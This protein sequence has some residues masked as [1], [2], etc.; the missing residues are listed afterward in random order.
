M[1]KISYFIIALFA[2]ASCEKGVGTLYQE[3]SDDGKEIHFLQKSVTK[4]FTKGLTEGTILVDIARPGKT[5]TY[6]VWL[7]LI[8]DDKEHFTVPTKVEIK[9][10]EYSTPVEIKVDLASLMVGSDF[11]STLYIYDREAQLG[12]DAT[13]DTQFADKMDIKVS[14]AL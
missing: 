5:G 6:A 14:F 7:N 2:L 13:W 3:K 12:T 8:G 11:K 4:E 1:R 10:G 9:D